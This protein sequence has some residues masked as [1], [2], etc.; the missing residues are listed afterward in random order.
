LTAAEKKSFERSVA[1]EREL[2]E[3]KDKVIGGLDQRIRAR[4]SEKISG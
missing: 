4:H 2:F 3:A 1:H